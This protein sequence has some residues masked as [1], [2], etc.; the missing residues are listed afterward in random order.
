ME[1]FLTATSTFIEKAT[2]TRYFLLFTSFLILTDTVLCKTI[3]TPLLQFMYSDVANKLQLGATL[4]YM[5]FFLFYISVF[6][7]LTAYTLGLLLNLLPPKYPSIFHNVNEGKYKKDGYISIY[8]L[9]NEAISENNSV[10]L[11]I[12]IKQE[13]KN[14]DELRLYQL[15]FTFLFTSILS[16]F[17]TFNNQ[18]SI[19]N[20]AFDFFNYSDDFI[21]PII[22]LI[23]IILIIYCIALGIGG[24]CL[25]RYTNRYV[26]ISNE[27]IK[28]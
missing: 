10:K 3:N 5:S 8:E 16:F 15:S 9:K 21:Q 24:Y 17:I 25:N 28:A 12:C 18:G 13:N 2:D 4:I 27:N 20:M 19:L 14:N 23:M 6:V 26:Y 1:K 7:P 22:L 11:N